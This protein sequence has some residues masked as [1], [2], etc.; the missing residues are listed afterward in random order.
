MAQAH[1]AAEGTRGGLTPQSQREDLAAIRRR[2]TSGQFA[3]RADT[4]FS[5]SMEVAAMSAW[6]WT[7]SWFW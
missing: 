3:D 2:G 5:K 6:M 7:I 1:G 4:S